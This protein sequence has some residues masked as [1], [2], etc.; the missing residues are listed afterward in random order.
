M[1]DRMRQKDEQEVLRQSFLWNGLGDD[2]RAHLMCRL[3]PPAKFSH[4]ETVYTTNRFCQAFGI[5]L[6]GELTVTMHG[7]EG[8][9][10]VMRYLTAGQ[11]FGVA[12]MF[13]EVE[14]YVSEV[15]AK[16][17]CIVQFISETELKELCFENPQ[18]ALNYIRFLSERIRFLNRKIHVF[19]C[20]DAIQRLYLHLQSHVTQDGSIAFSASMAVLARQLGIGRS[21]LYRSFSRLEEAGLIQKQN[22]IWYIKEP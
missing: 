6:A 14:S 21:T 4:S 12:A 10:V 9:G 16:S 18:I 11:V 3:S 8:H 22:G 20:N 17:D 2:T 5:V 19:T 13:G 7:S 15:V 1:I